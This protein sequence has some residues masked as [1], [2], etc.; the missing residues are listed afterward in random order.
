M[1]MEFQYIDGETK[2]F[3]G[4]FGIVTVTYYAPA[5]DDGSLAFYIGRKDSYFK[6]RLGNPSEPVTSM[7]NLAEDVTP[8]SAVRKLYKQYAE[9]L[10]L[11]DLEKL[12]SN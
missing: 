1:K 11:T 8:E 10:A 2:T 12:R 4:Y 9:R 6:A 3:E 5:K 7:Y